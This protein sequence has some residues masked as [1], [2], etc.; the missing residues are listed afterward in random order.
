VD[1]DAPVETA[2]LRL[3]PF[4][5]ADE[6]QLVRFFRDDHVRHYMLDGALVEQPWVAAE[7]DGSRRRFAA[8]ELGLYA[9]RP[10]DGDEIIGVTG[11]RPFHEPPVTE[12]LYALLPA[13]CGRG[14]AQEMARVMVEHAFARMPW[15]LLHAAVDEPN[16]GSIRVLEKLG[17][18][19]AG[20]SP[21]AFGRTLHFT[22]A[23]ERWR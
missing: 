6:D 9:A 10:R 2:R 1:S 21:G 14:L 18:E 4:A 3:S 20:A 23:R 11:Y 8:G 22:L 13:W 19:P 17:F 5:A 16:R 12:L 7:I 15:P